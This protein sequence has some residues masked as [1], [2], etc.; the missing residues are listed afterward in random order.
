MGNEPRFALVVVCLTSFCRRSLSCHVKVEKAFRLDETKLEQ[1]ARLMGVG[2]NCVPCVFCDVL[3]CT[4]SFFFSIKELIHKINHVWVK[5][6]SL[7]SS[8]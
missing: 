5:T 2:A 8:A 3:S 6:L 4:V 7:V 1:A